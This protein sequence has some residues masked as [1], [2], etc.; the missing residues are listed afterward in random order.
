MLRLGASGLIAALWRAWPSMR[1]CATSL[2]FTP[3]LAASARSP[4]TVSA[5]SKTF[6][7]LSRAMLHTFQNI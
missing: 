6:I 3:L 2:R 5:V 4:S 7:C 1:P